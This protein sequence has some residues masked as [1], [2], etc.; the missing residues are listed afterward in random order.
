MISAIVVLIII[1]HHVSST[2]NE[3][4]I[5]DKLD[6]ILRHLSADKERKP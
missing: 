2:L 3:A 5:V 1:I 4:R 6:R